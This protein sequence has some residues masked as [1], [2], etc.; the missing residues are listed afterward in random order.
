MQT[1]SPSWIWIA[2]LR[3][4]L[5]IAL[6]VITYLAVTPPQYTHAAHLNDK[7]QHFAAFYALALL[8]DF[9]FPA[10]RFDKMKLGFLLSY[11]LAIE[12]IQYFIPYR[13]FSWLDFAADTLGIMFFMLSIPLLLRIP[14][15]SWR[16]AA[17][18]QS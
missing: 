8:M 3:I 10:R 15:L 6:V 14:L 7:L 11:G 9:S 2:C 1:I 13:T 5:L 17:A 4:V 12:M 18:Q 16:R